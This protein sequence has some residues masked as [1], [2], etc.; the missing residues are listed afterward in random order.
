MKG[1]K[2]QFSGRWR[3]WFLGWCVGL[4][5]LASSNPVQADIHHLHGEDGSPLWAGQG[6]I[7][8]RVFRPQP[9]HLKGQHI[10][11]IGM[12]WDGPSQVEWQARFRQNNGTWGAWLTARTTWSE[13]LL[14]NSHV[15]PPQGWTH[16]VEVR[17]LGEAHPTFVAIELLGKLGPR[18]LPYVPT[19][20]GKPL[21]ANPNPGS[22][23]IS[24]PYNPRSVWKA[25]N[26][27]CSTR[28]ATKKR[29]AIHHTVTPNNDSA[30]PESRLRG[31]QSYHQGTQG[32]C[33]IGYHLLI[34]QDGRAWEGRPA[35]LLGT[36]V[37]SNNTN[38]LGISFMG[39]FT[40]VTP[41]NKMLCT[42]AKLIDWAVKTFGIPRN[43]NAIWGHRQFPKNST[44][45]PGDKLY[46][47]ISNMVTQ[48]SQGGNCSSGPPPKCD[49]VKTVR[50]GGST[51][52]IRKSATASSQK[53]GDMPE[54]TCLKVLAKNDNG[55]SVSGNTTW[56][57]IQYNSITGWISGYYADCST[58]TPPA[59]AKGTLKGLVYDKNVGKS[60]KLGGA[61][62]AISGSSTLTTKNDGTFGASLAPKTYT[63]KVTLSGYKDASKQVKIESNKT[64]N[65]E[66]ALEPSTPP[67][68]IQAPT[69]TIT[70]PKDGATLTNSPVQVEGTI[71][72]NQN[73]TKAELNGVSLTL[74][75]QGEFQQ[76]LN[77]T[78][79]QQ[80]IQVD[81]WDP[82]GNKGTQQIT[83]VYLGDNESNVEPQQDAALPEP[84]VTPT[85]A[86]GQEPATQPDATAPTDDK[87]LVLDAAVGTPCTQ[88]SECPSGYVCDVGSCKPFN[89]PTLINNLGGGCQCSGGGGTS[90][91]LAL[92]FVVL[93]L[94]RR[95]RSPAV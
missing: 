60:K 44:A 91:P 25:A 17:Y 77:L 62:V 79:G 85:D 2:Q 48:S 74:G 76:Y 51:L 22:L 64:A 92:L 37:G 7:L 11:R 89:S 63:L 90:L 26:A 65:V 73:V 28:D 23:G 1:T 61:N 19:T 16:E 86:G 81:A 70:A 75:A 35:D 95:R 21:P 14:H 82:A 39:T 29:I 20:P 56:Y 40:S 52:N 68:D 83:V 69:I 10:V 54:G 9:L 3:C 32:W 58:C 41:N 30:S 38:T 78:P 31:I 71:T 15:D 67:Q 49:N 50:L 53:L 88:P 42:G 72:D 13:G 4:V 5:L 57:Q 94:F 59:P 87:P 80:T 33:D 66:F 12:R 34:S 6:A 55:Q 43:R 45:C 27:K 47:Q 8:Q 46:A 24:G 84:P 18:A 36:H 93:L